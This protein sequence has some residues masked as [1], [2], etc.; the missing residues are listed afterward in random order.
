MEHQK[1][2]NMLNEEGYSKFIT[3]NWN[4][5]NN[6]LN[7]NYCV[8]SEIIYSIEVL[9]FDISDYNDAYILI[10]H[11]ITVIGLNLA[12]EVAFKNF[13]PFIKCISKI[14]ETTTDN[15]EDLDLV[16]PVYNLL[17]YVSNYSDTA[18]SL[19]FFSLKIKQLIL[20]L[21]LRAM[22]LLEGII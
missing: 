12:T 10:E 19:C 6:Q 1:M 13:A 8:E 5:V 15:A 14:D 9:K 22:M 18:D 4:I 2:L 17:E 11:D 3:R 7:A 21:I 16:M 20:M